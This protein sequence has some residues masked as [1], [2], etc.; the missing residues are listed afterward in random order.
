MDI[1]FKVISGVASVLAI[2]SLYMYF[3][4]G[5]KSLNQKLLD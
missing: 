3:R 5:K 1:K 2:S 4:E